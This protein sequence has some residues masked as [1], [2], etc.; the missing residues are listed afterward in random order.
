MNTTKCL[1]FIEFIGHKK[2][3]PNRDGIRFSSFGSFP[4][5]EENIDG[6]LSNDEMKNIQCFQDKSNNQENAKDIFKS[7][8]ILELGI[9]V[10][11]LKQ[12]HRMPCETEKDDRDF[13]TD[14]PIDTNAT[15]NQK[16]DRTDQTD[17]IEEEFSDSLEKF[18]EMRK[19]Q[20]E[21]EK[22]L[23]A[24]RWHLYS[25]DQTISTFEKLR[26]RAKDQRELQEQSMC[27]VVPHWHPWYLNE[28]SC[29]INEKMRKREFLCLSFFFPF[30]KTNTLQTYHSD[31]NPYS[32][33]PLHS[34][35]DSCDSNGKSRVSRENCKSES[36]VRQWEE[37]DLPCT[38]GELILLLLRSLFSIKN[39]HG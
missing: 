36:I 1:D 37:I 33:S 10:G 27:F 34:H 18:E 15:D 29:F 9:I 4:I 17:D 31:K 3:S 14:Q 6:T 16:N 39:E 38:S 12:K 25:I 19:R 7:I 24:D 2:T 26:R 11:S 30:D 5:H 21:R 8:S 22:G 32:L 13:E 20:R 28:F 35:V 23:L